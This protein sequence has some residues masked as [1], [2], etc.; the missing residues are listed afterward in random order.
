[1]EMELKML[2]LLSFDLFVSINE[3]NSTVHIFNQKIKHQRQACERETI[4][5]SQVGNAEISKRIRI[6]RNYKSFNDLTH[7]KEVV[8][9]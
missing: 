4:D 9:I 3:Y 6:S 8:K 7:S 1:M 5:D 2:D